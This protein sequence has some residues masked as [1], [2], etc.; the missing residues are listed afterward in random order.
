MDSSAPSPE[1][2]APATGQPSRRRLLLRRLLLL[3]ILLVTATLVL[4]LAAHTLFP[5]ER[6][7]GVAQVRIAK[8]PPHVLDGPRMTEGDDD[9]VAVPQDQIALIKSRRVFNAVLRDPKVALLPIVK[10]QTDPL[11]WL[12]KQIQV[13][14]AGELLSIK[15]TGKDDKAPVEIVRAVRTV[16]LDEVVN[17]ERTQRLKRYDQLRDIYKEKEAMLKQARKEQQRFALKAGEDSQGLVPRDV[18]VQDLLDC[19]RE[20]RRVQL[21]RAAA[22]VPDAKEGPLSLKALIAQEKLLLEQE[23]ALEAKCST[24]REA[25]ELS[26]EITSVE[27]LVKRLGDMIEQ[28]N[29]ETR[30]RERI[31]AYDDPFVIKVK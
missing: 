21:A 6:Y 22:S 12:D 13:E 18:V 16:Y 2:S 17:A 11:D 25:I 4:A 20:L 10:E 3:P 31:T 19:N 24:P 1:P 14:V 26:N 9:F 5:V 15:M 28:Q 27:A 8:R 23:K 30:A 7:I 29:V